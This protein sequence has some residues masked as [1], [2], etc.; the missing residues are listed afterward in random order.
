MRSVQRMKCSRRRVSRGGKFTLN[1]LLHECY[2][3]GMFCVV[4]CLFFLSL[5]KLIT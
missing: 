3:E 5:R 2:G 4:V 1:G